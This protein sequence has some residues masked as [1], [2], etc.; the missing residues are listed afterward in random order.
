MQRFF[1]LTGHFAIASLLTFFLAS[2]VHSQFVLYGLTDIGISISLFERL[3]MTID[4]IQGLFATLGAIISLSLLL[5]FLT[6]Y[7]LT[8]MA[9]VNRI[10]HLLYP[11]A[12]AVA[13]WVMLAAMHPI[14]N[15][16]V[17]AS[18]RSGLGLISLSMCGMVGGAIFWRLRKP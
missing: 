9:S 18:A 11:L 5:G 6:T 16:T 3:T 10:K 7:F 12:G 14:M 4:D 8:K 13:I 1:I 15:I 2:V 17:L